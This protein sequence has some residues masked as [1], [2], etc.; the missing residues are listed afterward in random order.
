VLVASPAGAAPKGAKAKAAFDKGVA[1]YQKNDYAAAAAAFGKSYGL[2]VDPETLFAWAQAERKQEHCDKANELYTKL[3]A[4]DLPDA[5]RN[6]IKGQIAECEQILDA[7][8]PKPEPTKVETKPEPTKVETKPEPAKVET[9]PEPAKV[10]PATPQPPVEQ[11]LPPGPVEGRPWYRDPVGDTLMIGGL[12][13]LG[14]GAAMLVTAHSAEQDEASAATYPEAKALDDKAKSRGEIGVIATGV[15]AAL[16]V[17]GIVWYATHGK[18][19]HAPTAW[20]TPTGG[21]VGIAGA[22]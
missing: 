11:P 19:S 13:G 18:P 6:V 5:N 20:L 8:K 10:E 17:S 9:K 15:G 12:A 1:A 2:E 4:M 22:F 3:L 14:I 21:A 7:K 16:V